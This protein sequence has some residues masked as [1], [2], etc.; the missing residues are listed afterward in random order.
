MVLDVKGLFYI[1]YQSFCPV[2]ELG[3]PNPSPASL[4][5]PTTQVGVTLLCGG[6]GGGANSDDWIETPVLYKVWSLRLKETAVLAG[7]A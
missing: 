3:P 7:D 5:P 1:E 6:G 4:S 2:F